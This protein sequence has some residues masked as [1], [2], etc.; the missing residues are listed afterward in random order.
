MPPRYQTCDTL[1]LL[2]A[3]KLITLYS[4]VTPGQWTLAHVSARAAR[5]RWVTSPA[6]WAGGGTLGRG[7]VSSETPSREDSRHAAPET[8]VTTSWHC[9]AN[10]WHHRQVTWVLCKLDNKQ[11]D[12]INLHSFTNKWV[13]ETVTVYEV[14]K[15]FSIISM[16]ILNGK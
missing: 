15:I 11:W 12:L 5:L 4:G 9:H 2:L 6:R 10:T 7:S 13:E 8:S 16:N 3:Y 1:L 14:M